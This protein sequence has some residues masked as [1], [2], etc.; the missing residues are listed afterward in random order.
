MKEGGGEEETHKTSRSVAN[1]TFVAALPISYLTCS[2]IRD[3]AVARMHTSLS[4]ALH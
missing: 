2:L 4:S 1:A 3:Y